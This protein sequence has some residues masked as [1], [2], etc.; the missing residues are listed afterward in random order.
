MVELTLLS[1]LFLHSLGSCLDMTTDGLVIGICRQH[2][3]QQVGNLGKRN[4]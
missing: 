3:V 2:L 4:P 1:Q